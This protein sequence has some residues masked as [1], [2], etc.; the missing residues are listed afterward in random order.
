MAERLYPHL[1]GSDRVLENC[2]KCDPVF[3][4]EGNFVTSGRIQMYSHVDGGVCYACW[5]T[6]RSSVL[7]S[8]VRAREGARR[9]ARAKAER[10]AAEA[11]A[12]RA[13]FE[14]EHQEFLTA[15]AA[16][17]NEWVKSWTATIQVP[18]EAQM[19]S[20]LAQIERDNAEAAR[21]AAAE[22]VPDTAER[23]KI[24]GVIVGFKPVPA[25]QPWQPDVLKAIVLDDRGFKV[26]GTCAMAFPNKGERVEFMAKVERS[27]DDRLFGFYSR[28]TKVKVLEEANA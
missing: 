5:G 21:Q 26:Y 22:S 23:I 3:D 17:E 28:P 18:T 9:R 13:A 27:R 12:A 25:F 24:T 11:E 2:W 20:A 19:A 10:E 15:A 16:S 8:T 7:V 4:A 14:A 6:G 1:K